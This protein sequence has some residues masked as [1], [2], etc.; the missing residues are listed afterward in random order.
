MKKALIVVLGV[1]IIIPLLVSCASSKKVVT[2]VGEG[3]GEVVKGTGEGV[4]ELGKGAAG[5][6]KGTTGAVGYTLAGQTDKAKEEGKVAADSAGS[7]I[8]GIVQEP[9]EGLGKGL[10]DIDS[11]IKEATRSDDVK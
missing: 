2:G 1:I 10:Q 7:G 8:K 6:V 11:G 9:L 3:T 4:L 5:T